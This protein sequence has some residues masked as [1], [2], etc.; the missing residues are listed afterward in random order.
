MLYVTVES[1]TLNVKCYETPMQENVAAKITEP[2]PA[3]HSPLVDTPLPA[4]PTSSG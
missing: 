4:G 3:L 2:F 1:K